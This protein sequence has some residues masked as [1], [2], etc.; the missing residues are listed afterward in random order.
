MLDWQR[1]GECHGQTE[2]VPV[3][4]PPWESTDAERAELDS[5]AKAI[6]ATC[7]VKMTCREHSL[8]LPELCGTWGGV[9]E[10]ERVTILRRKRRGA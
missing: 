9:T 4:Y 3:F 10:E 7:P 1:D 2:L 8:A 6:C 5:R